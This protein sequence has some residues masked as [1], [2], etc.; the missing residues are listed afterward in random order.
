MSPLACMIAATAHSRVNTKQW[1]CW[2]SSFATPTLCCS[3]GYSS[4]HNTRTVTQ[5]QVKRVGKN[6]DT[7][8]FLLLSDDNVKRVSSHFRCSRLDP[9]Y[10]YV[11]LFQSP[12]RQLVGQD[13]LF[14]DAPRSR[15]AKHTTL[16]RT[17]LNE[18]SAR[19]D[20][21]HHAQQT[22]MHDF[23]GIRT[24]KPSYLAAANPHL[25]PRGHWDWHGLL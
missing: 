14:I 18:W 2:Q 4:E 17:P 21:M 10:I 23:G 12:Q 19:P 11:L 24:R 1:G 20:N 22:N 13:L 16:G 25:R 8:S 9:N 6:Q 3:Y 5:C 15:T 7:G